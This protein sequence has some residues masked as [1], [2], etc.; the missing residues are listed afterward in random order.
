[1]T[2]VLRHNE[3]LELNRVEYSGSV[4]VA[5]LTALAEF[6]TSTPAWLGYDCLN[7]VAPNTDFDTVD[8]D[9]LDRLFAQYA[10]L[11]QPLSFFI[12]RRSAWVCESP[13]AM[14]HVRHWAG[15][16]ET[17]ETMK[18]DVRIFDTIETAGEWLL[19]RQTEFDTV[20]AGVGFQDIIRIHNPPDAAR[21]L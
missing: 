10:A 19:L 13:L 15:G 7:L 17:K 6:Q 9:E 8:L 1:M 2:I 14:R 18:S 12:M 16:R 3:R 11:F 5:E 21:A 20:R 4:G